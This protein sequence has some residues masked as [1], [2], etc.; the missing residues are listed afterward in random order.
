MSAIPHDILVQF[1]AWLADAA[2][3]P[4]ILEPTAMVL[5][6]VHPDG[7]PAARVVL[8]KAIDAD[9]LVFYTNY[10]SDKGRD[11]AA[12]PRAAMCFHW[13]P[14]CRQI[15]VQGEVSKVDADESD[16][17][18]STRP[19]GSQLGAWASD[20]SRPLDA[21]STLMERFATF[22]RRFAG[23]PVPRPPHWG[24]YRLVPDRVEFWR[25]LND[26]LHER[27]LHVQEGGVWTRRKLF[28]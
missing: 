9:G 4:S 23:G 21:Y 16:A 27:D 25:S 11:L 1:Q 26:R 10:E 20:Q 7:M 24:G 12:T 17:Y 8:L 6:T 3:Q 5:A 14:L 18:F 15:R 22:E 19:I 13:D 2:A 28:P